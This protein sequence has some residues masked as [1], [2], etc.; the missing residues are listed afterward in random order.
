LVQ[1]I[2]GKAM[3]TSTFNLPTNYRRPIDPVVHGVARAIDRAFPLDAAGP[4]PANLARLASSVDERRARD[5][6]R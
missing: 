6:D 5:A 3:R 4:L 2:R 1:A